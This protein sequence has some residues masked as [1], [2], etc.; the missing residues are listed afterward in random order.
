MDKHDLLKAVKSLALELGK[1]PS[2]D[3]FVS[4]TCYT[5]HHIE[6]MFG[7][8]TLL[9]Q[10]AGLKKSPKEESQARKQ[11]IKQIFEKPYSYFQ[12]QT[13]KSSPEFLHLQEYTETICIGD[14][15]APWI[16]FDALSLTYALIEKLKPK[17]IVQLGDSRDF[18]AYSKFP[19]SHITLNPKEEIDQGTKQ[20]SDMW[21][22]IQNIAPKASCHMILGNHDIRAH[23]RLIEQCPTLEPLIDLKPL[24]TFDGVETN[25]STRNPLVIDNITYTH[26]HRSKSIQHLQDFESNVVHGHTHNGGLSYQKY[27]GKWYWVLDCGYLGD[28]T[29]KIFHYTAVKSLK[30]SKG[31]GYISKHGPHWIPFE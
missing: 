31:I 30:W 2:R 7:S 10:A 23:K 26:G 21:K 9:T 18:Y 25:H 24:F 11:A 5:R 19:R 3:E 12:N 13:Q 27:N 16:D 28:E 20:L 22:T 8:Y 15:H 1:I 17:V 29:K 6:K 14:L 4:T